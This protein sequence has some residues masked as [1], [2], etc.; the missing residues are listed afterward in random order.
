VTTEQQLKLQAYADGELPEREAHKVELLLQDDRDAAKLLAE[1]KN[2]R[3]AL[4]Q[5]EPQIQFPET[6]EFYW[7]K[8]AREIRK[9]KPEKELSPMSCNWRRL[10]WPISLTAGAIAVCFLT[11]ILGNP[12]ADRSAQAAAVSSDADAPVVETAQADSDAMTYEDKSDGTTLV[13]FSTDDNPAP[14]KTF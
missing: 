5:N 3:Q 6:R 10:L 8:I 4:T 2:T 13:W 14:S 11:V 9:L 12:V 1:L 7:S